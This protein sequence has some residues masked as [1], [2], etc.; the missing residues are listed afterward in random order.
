MLINNAFYFKNTSIFVSSVF[1]IMGL[2]KI[3]G[4]IRLKKLSSLGL[5]WRTAVTKSKN[6]MTSLIISS[7]YVLLY[8]CIKK[9]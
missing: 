4:L 3:S 8:S 2:A 1:N 9:N 6:Y 7:L 5:Y